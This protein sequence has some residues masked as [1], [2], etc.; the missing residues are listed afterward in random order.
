MAETMKKGNGYAYLIVIAL[1]LCLFL[2]ECFAL[3]CAGIIFP[4]AAEAFGVT[5]ATLSYYIPMMSVVNIILL[6]I[7]GKL[8][9]KVDVRIIV[10]AC[11]VATALGF[12]I[13]SQATQLWHYYACALL[14]GG[15][16]PPLLFIAPTTITNKW[17]AK[18]RA[19]FFIGLE[20][21]AMG[22]GG[23]IWN[24]IGGMIIQNYGW[25][26]CLLMF[27]ILTLCVLPFTIFVL[28]GDPSEKGM[29][30]VGF[31]PATETEVAAPVNEEGIMASEAMRIPGF[32]FFLAFAVCLN[33]GLY[34]YQMI[35]SYIN[36]MPI[37]AELPLLGAT[38]ASVALAS[39]T[40]SKL[41]LG[42]VGEK[43]PIPIIFVTLVLGAVGVLAVHAG[44]SVVP[45]IVAGV[46][47]Y[48]V[49][50]AVTNV[51][52]PIVTRQ[53]FGMKDY[54]QIYSRV[55]MAASLGNLIGSFLWGT[56][57]NVTGSYDVLFIGTAIA[58]VLAMVTIYGTSASMKKYKAQQS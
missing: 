33:L 36:S 20:M 54:S 48:G 6:P 28:R 58:M 10:S 29:L 3:S 5:P 45:I 9:T 34:F 25:R 2:P 19:G 31:N 56:L 38:L 24:P 15:A 18:S 39:Q 16:M 55:S 22:I 7:Y 23:I 32:I 40:V 41:V 17:F 47:C 30:P 42:A 53:Y 52:N 35:P 37:G 4:H 26:S 43:K 51:M 12:F 46:I 14:V 57:I 44:G 13:E 8:F 50:Y 11:V 21:T 1:F 27:A 49:Y